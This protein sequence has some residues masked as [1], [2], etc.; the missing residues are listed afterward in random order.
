MVQA[1]DLLGQKYGRLL[2][3]ERV[4]SN[5]HGQAT[6]RCVCDCGRT[7]MVV[8]SKLKL[9]KT[10]SCGCIKREKTTARNYKHGASYRDAR[11]KEYLAWK[12]MKRRC[13]NKSC[14]SYQWY[15]AK[16]IGVHEA[17]VNDFPQF[18]ADVGAAPS[19]KH[20]LDRINPCFGYTPSNVRWSTELVQSQN[21]ASVVNNVTYMGE[22]KCLA[23]WARDS[24]CAVSYRTLVAR[25]GTYGWGFHEAFTTPPLTRGSRV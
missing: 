6:W 22:T 23:E 18:L 24:R 17:W 2:V 4:T 21:R 8:A 12:G 3:V 1:L 13:F 5:A 25:V 11:T 16:G 19:T 10:Q 9:N 14:K 7:A 20:E 15:G